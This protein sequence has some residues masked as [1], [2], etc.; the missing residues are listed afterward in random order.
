MAATIESYHS[1]VAAVQLARLQEDPT[2]QNS[3]MHSAILQHIPHAP[4]ADVKES[5]VGSG[6]GLGKVS[7]SS[8]KASPY[9]A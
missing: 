4:R 8:T 3:M 9:E 5:G 1:M 6:K 2:A 7:T